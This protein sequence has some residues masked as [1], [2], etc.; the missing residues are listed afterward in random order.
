MKIK[1]QIELEVESKQWDVRGF[2][3]Q[4]QVAR[5]ERSVALKGSHSEFDDLVSSLVDNTSDLKATC[6]KFVVIE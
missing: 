1:L 2:S 6:T 4:E 5:I 3:Q